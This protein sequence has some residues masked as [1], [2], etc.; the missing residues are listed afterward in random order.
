LQ[1]KKELRSLVKIKGKAMP[2]GLATELWKKIRF[3]DA[4][5]IDRELYMVFI[6]AALVS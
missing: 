4:L 2:V 3:H 5:R 1:S 6:I